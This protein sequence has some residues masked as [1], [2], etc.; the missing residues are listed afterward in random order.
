MLLYS[1]DLVAS[2]IP[3]VRRLRAFEKIEL[4]PGVSATVEF[5]I[6]ASDLAFVGADGKWRLESGDFKIYCGSEN[7]SIRCTEDKIWKSPNIL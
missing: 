2:I 4:E 6:P 7:L 5:A 1:E 3:D